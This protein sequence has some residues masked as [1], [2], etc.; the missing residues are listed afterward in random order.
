[1]CELC[2]STLGEYF[3]TYKYIFFSARCCCSILLVEWR[4]QN[5]THKI[6]RCWYKMV[7]CKRGVWYTYYK[8]KRNPIGF[9]PYVRGKVNC[10]IIRKITLLSKLWTLRKVEYVKYIVLSVYL[11]YC[12]SHKYI[13]QFTRSSLKEIL[14]IP[15]AIG[16]RIVM[17]LLLYSVW[18]WLPNVES[19]A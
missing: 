8:L 1:M 7:W 12:T 13:F 6:M 17:L 11:L 14:F 2:V 3:R 15:A 10:I 19:I 16:S 9:I 5:R 4:F 18:F